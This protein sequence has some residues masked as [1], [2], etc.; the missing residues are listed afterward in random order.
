MRG[1]GR[2]GSVTAFTLWL[3]IHAKYCGLIPSCF[4]VLVLY[5]G[6]NT[7]NHYYVAIAWYLPPSSF[8]DCNYMHLAVKHKSTDKS[9]TGQYCQYVTLQ[10][11][12]I[13]IT[14]HAWDAAYLSGKSLHKL[15]LLNLW[16]DCLEPAKYVPLNA[17][18]ALGALFLSGWNCRASFLYCLF[19]FSSVASSVTPKI[20]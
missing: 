20:L 3:K 18:S 12:D 19:K 8:A 13:F 4:F 5:G 6:R 16:F 9:R 11:G 7:K 15:R 10:M 14:K 1:T 17:S 2:D